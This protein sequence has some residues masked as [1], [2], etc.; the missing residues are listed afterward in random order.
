MPYG[1]NTSLL[2]SEAF[3]NTQTDMQFNG[4]RRRLGWESFYPDRQDQARHSYPLIADT[5]C[6]I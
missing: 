1:L 6:E 2:H 5:V 4:T 3:N